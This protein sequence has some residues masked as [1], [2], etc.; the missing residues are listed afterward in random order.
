MNVMF[1]GVGH[2]VSSMKD[3]GAG[4]GCCVNVNS[5][6]CKSSNDP[7]NKQHSYPTNKIP[8]P[9]GKYTLVKPKSGC[10]PGWVEGWRSQDNEDDKNNINSISSGHHFY[11]SFDKN[12][13]AYY[14]T[15]IRD[16]KVTDWTKW[17]LVLWPNGTYCIL[18]KGGSCPL[19]FANGYVYWDDEDDGNSNDIGGTLPDGKYD[20]ANTLIQYCCRSDGQPENAI[21]LPT[22]MAFYLVGKTNTSQQVKGMTVRKEYIKT[23]DED[24]GVSNRREGSYPYIE[25]TR[26]TKMLYCYYA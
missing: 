17:K 8:W 19:G 15:K 16:E 2:C 5:I 6:S 4:S 21:E 23:D 22:S 13:K 3:T 11:G 9:K 18:R 7:L 24:S 20:D 14:C 26:N 12:T 1:R 25:E 10:P